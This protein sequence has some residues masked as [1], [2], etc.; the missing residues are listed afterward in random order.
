MQKEQ[1]THISL[2]QLYGVFLN[3]NTVGEGNESWQVV[4]EKNSTEQIHNKCFVTIQLMVILGSLMNC[5]DLI[6]SSLVGLL[7]M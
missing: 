2:L 7:D 4:G 3:V 5:K 6:F 1:P